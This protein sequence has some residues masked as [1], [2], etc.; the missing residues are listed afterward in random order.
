MYMKNSLRYNEDFRSI[1]PNEYIEEDTLLW[2]E[3]EVDA[4]YNV[5]VEGPFVIQ[6]GWGPIWF[7][8]KNCNNP[9]P[10]GYVQI[11]STI[12]GESRRVTHGNFLFETYYVMNEE[13]LCT[14]AET[15]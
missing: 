2:V 10:K 9:Q 13:R 4:Y 1:T 3:R 5:E 15:L 6:N 11:V 7:G 8:P 12:T 14:D